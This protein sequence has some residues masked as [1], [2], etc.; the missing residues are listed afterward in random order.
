MVTILFGKSGA[1]KD[2]IERE[3]CRNHGHKHIVTT[4][5]RPMRPGEKDGVDY[6]YVTPEK[7][8]KMRENGQFIESKDYMP[9]SGGIWSYGSTLSD[10]QI[11]S[12]RRYILILTPAGIRDA[13]RVLKERNADM[14]RIM[15]VYVK[16][17]H[18]VRRQRLAHRGDNQK[19][20]NRR[21][22]ADDRDFKGAEKLA[23]YVLINEEI[24]P[25]EAG[26]I[27]DHAED[28]HSGRERH[29]SQKKD[30]QESEILDEF[31][32]GQTAENRN[33]AEPSDDYNVPGFELTD[34]SEQE[35]YEMADK[36]INKALEERDS[37]D[38]EDIEPDS[39]R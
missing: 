16:A 21:M 10:E 11:N 37:D 12:D 18:E 27:I 33:T 6:N 32:S 1:G 7:F 13:L 28:L 24:S 38:I 30:R 23:D 20:V 5:T 22:A 14:N 31:V 25:E 19:E 29:A 3:L 35:M 8:E 26:Y 17:G 9:A 15:T 4:T 36:M 34:P 39:G 2:T